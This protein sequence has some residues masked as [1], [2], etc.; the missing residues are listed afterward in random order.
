MAW[1]TNLSWNNPALSILHGSDIALR[2]SGR[3]LPGKKQGRDFIR[4]PVL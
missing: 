3:Q 2:M 4:V 1:L